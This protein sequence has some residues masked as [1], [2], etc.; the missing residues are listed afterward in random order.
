MSGERAP[1]P[2]APEVAAAASEVVERRVRVVN[3]MGMHA[4]PA[5]RFVELARGFDARVRVGCRGEEVDGRSIL[6]LLMLEAVKGTELVLRA[7]GP[8]ADEAASA[9]AA[10]VAAGFD[11]RWS[12]DGR[13][14]R[15]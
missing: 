13:G 5:G 11:E 8:E 6:S 14:A 1:D 3:P 15:G 7:R 4:R 9:L 10:L 12:W 2:G